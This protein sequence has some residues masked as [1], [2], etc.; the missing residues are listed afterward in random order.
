M[1]IQGLTKPMV[2]QSTDAK[3]LVKGPVRAAAAP[4]ADAPASTFE[5]E[6]AARAGALQG[7]APRPAYYP[8]LESLTRPT[9]AGSVDVRTGARMS[10]NPAQMSDAQGV[11][12]VQ[13]RLAA[14]GFTGS[15]TATNSTAPAA[16]PFGI[17]YGSDPRRH[18]DIGGLNVGLVLGMYAREAPDMAD[19]M[20]AAEM[21]RAR[22][23]P[24][25]DDG[26]PRLPYTPAAAA[27]PAPAFAAM[28]VLPGVDMAAA[29]AGATSVAPRGPRQAEFPTLE[30]L[31]RPTSAGSVDVRTGAR[32]SLNPA[33]MSSQRGVD[34]VRERLAALG[35]QGPGVVSNQT[36]P[37]AGPFGIDY[38]DDD[39][40]HWDIDGMN[41]GLTLQLYA[42]NPREVADR[43]LA[44]MLKTNAGR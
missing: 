12:F 28:R 5:A 1:R 11:A 2:T 40:R 14:L 44:D 30:D 43:M 35:Y 25:P 39:R 22:T 20:L 4:P 38:G 16:G 23:A 10:L 7:G 13:E 36:A 24:P 29:L 3:P 6:P 37:S 33:Q 8:T 17:D 21:Q 32:T 41:V 26:S 18:W 19:R 34:F 15:L 31:N 9:T 42:T 27:P